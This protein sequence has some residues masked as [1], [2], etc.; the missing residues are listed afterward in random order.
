[1]CR[2]FSA[3]GA[4]ARHCV[5]LPSAVCVRWAALARYEVCACAPMG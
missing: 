2:P 5:G 4:G 3:A 1:M